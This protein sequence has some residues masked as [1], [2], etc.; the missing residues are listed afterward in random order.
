[1]KKKQKKRRTALAPLPRRRAERKTKRVVSLV[2]IFSALISGA[3]A[4]FWLLFFIF[5]TFFSIP[6]IPVE[7]VRI[8]GG[9]PLDTIDILRKSGINKN[10]DIMNLN[11]KTAQKKL[12]SGE[13]Y[14]KDAAIIRNPVSAVIDINIKLRKPAAF[15]NTG[16]V[17]MGIDET[18][19]IIGGMEKIE[20][21]DLPVI[22]GLDAAGSEAGDILAGDKITAALEIIKHARENGLDSEAPVSEINISDMRNIIIYAGGKGMQIRLGAENLEKKMR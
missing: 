16:G 21:T 5:S 12:I 2:F 7:R 22:T 13:P 9:G 10:T 1:M 20:L 17:L 15:V 3:L 8:E 19:V 14:I 18:G 6:S 4:V 11:L